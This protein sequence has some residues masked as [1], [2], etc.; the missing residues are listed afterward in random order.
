MRHLNTGRGHHHKA[1]ANTRRLFMLSEV[2]G[3]AAPG[4]MIGGTA[5]AVVGTPTLGTDGWLGP[6]YRGFDGSTMALTGGG[7]GS[8]ATQL[9]ANTWTLGLVWR[10]RASAAGVIFCFGG[11]SGLL[12]AN[13]LAR[14]KMAADGSLTF[15]WEDAGIVLRSVA[16]PTYKLPLNKWVYVHIVRTGATSVQVWIN[17]RLI[18]TLA[19]TSANAGGTTSIWTIAEDE[20]A[21]SKIQGDLGSL[22]LE[23]TALTALP[24]YD[25]IRRATLQ[26]F[27][28][29]VRARVKIKN[30]LGSFVDLTALEGQDFVDGFELKED[31][32]TPC[33]SCTLNLVREIELLSLANLMTSSK[34]NL[35]NVANLSSY[36]PLVDIQRELLIEM[37]RVPLGQ[38]A[39]STDWVQRFHGYVDE[40]DWGGDGAIAVTARDDGGRLVDD[41]LSTDIKMPITSGGA[42]AADPVTAEIRASVEEATQDLLNQS[43]NTIWTLYAPSP[44]NLC[45]VPWEQKKD[46]IMAAARACAAVKAWDFGFMFDESPGQNTLRATLID[47]GRS[48]IDADGIID[49]SDYAQLNRASLDVFQVRNRV[50][51]TF[52]DKNNVVETQADGSIVKAPKTLTPSTDGTSRTK[53]GGLWRTIFI[54]EGDTSPIDEDAE[55]QAMQDGILADLKDPLV[56]VDLDDVVCYFEAELYDIYTLVGDNVHWTGDQ[57]TAVSAVKCSYKNGAGSV[58]LGMRGQPTAGVRRWLSMEVRPGMP[59]QSSYTTTQKASH[60]VP[61]GIKAQV[62]DLIARQGG[63]GRGLRVDLVRNGDF[64]QNNRGTGFMPD[65]WLRSL[66]TTTSSPFNGANGTSDA[67]NANVLWGTKGSRSGRGYI[68]F[69]GN[70]PTWQVASDF[71]PIRGGKALTKEFL[72]M[73]AGTAAPAAGIFEWYDEKKAYLSNQNSVPFTP[74]TLNIATID[75]SG[76]G[77]LVEV[78]TALAHGLS[79]GDSFCVNGTVNYQNLGVDGRGLYTVGVV[80]STTKVTTTTAS[81]GGLAAEVVGRISPWQRSIT[82][83]VNAPRAARFGRYIFGGCISGDY[84]YDKLSFFETSP[85]VRAFLSANATPITDAAWTKIL[86]NSENVDT[87][88]AYDNGAAATWTCPESGMYRIVCTLSAQVTGTTCTFSALSLRLNLNAGTIIAQSPTGAYVEAAAAATVTG[89]VQVAHSF[90]FTKGD[91]LTFEGN[92]TRVTGTTPVR[93]W[94]G[95]TNDTWMHIKQ[96]GTE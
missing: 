40:I 14:L 59:N 66:T 82:L 64:S 7:A 34:L 58:S 45:L 91:T 57:V 54:T 1:T 53:Y 69:V 13:V 22:Y 33:E 74:Q 83:S 75:D 73:Y 31:A 62:N 85:E 92:I 27:P 23:T 68:C 47:P 41:F 48:R 88:N 18:A 94:V 15:E 8:D 11:N 81:G 65:G 87:D 95:G 26:V 70:N 20:S 43:T 39:A 46:S 86:F 42:C 32:D 5:L 3:G 9:T 84:Y 67:T 28:T 36:S 56:M 52:G 50:F 76:A 4:D 51:L 17:G 96:I 44:A 60:A 71:F 21:A 93:A 78:T 38:A 37:A 77:N 79:V 29:S 10:R 16:I 6:N 89:R 49:R 61:I 25:D 19:M 2:L 55:A 72:S 12:A 63:V 35:T 24:I 80:V 30:G 90:T